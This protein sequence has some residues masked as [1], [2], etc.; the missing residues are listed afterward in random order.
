VGVFVVPLPA[1]EADAN[2]R[3]EVIAATTRAA[4]TERSAPSGVFVWLSGMRPLFERQRM[5]NFFVTDVPG[6]PV[7]LYVLGAR[8]EQVIPVVGL[9]ANL[10]MV[11]GALSYCGRLNLVVNADATSCSSTR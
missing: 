7:P 3:L 1:G 6:P 2:R 9:A 11:F 4:K 5:A 10:T 8:I